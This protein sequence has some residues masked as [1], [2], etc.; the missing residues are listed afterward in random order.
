[1]V[2]RITKYTAALA[3]IIIITGTP[4]T[5]GPKLEL[6][7]GQGINGIVLAVAASGAL[8]E[9]AFTIPLVPLFMITG[10]YSPYFIQEQYGLTSPEAGLINFGSLSGIGAGA[11]LAETLSVSGRD[12]GGY[13]FLSD[14][15][16]TV[17]AAAYA[18]NREYELTEGD[19]SLII[20]ATVFSSITTAL[21]ANAFS[22]GMNSRSNALALLTG[23]TA[24]LAAS[25]IMTDS[26]DWSRRRVLVMDMC[27]AGGGLTGLGFA[28]LFK[29][30][31]RPKFFTAVITM[32]GGAAAGYYL[33]EGFAP[34]AKPRL[35]TGADGRSAEK[36]INFTMLQRSF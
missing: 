24:G 11:A 27:I 28:K 10:I 26:L 18:F 20:S 22:P 2:N 33:T 30:S 21:T 6:G 32:A 31:E 1:M 3:A 16:F 5:A 35:Q 15:L 12:T 4:L 19:L 36:T 23:G 29:L 7:T 34:E 14:S 13:I 17:S 9:W 8:N 25:V